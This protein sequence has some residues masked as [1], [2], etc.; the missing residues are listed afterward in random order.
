MFNWIKEE[1]TFIS[2]KGELGIDLPPN[3]FPFIKPEDTEWNERYAEYNR[4]GDY[5]NA[6]ILPFV[7]GIYIAALV[8]VKKYILA[9]EKLEVLTHFIKI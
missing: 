6:G 9:R 7:S 1:C 5:Q 4:Q 2:E 8:A 3:F